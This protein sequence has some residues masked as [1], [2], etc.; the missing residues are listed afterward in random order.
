MKLLIKKAIASRNTAMAK[1]T[2]RNAEKWFPSTFEIALMLTGIV[3]FT[4]LVFNN[5]NEKS[6]IVYG[7]E[8]LGYWRKG[9]WELLE[10][11]MQMILI[12]VLGYALAVS[13]QVSNFLDIISKKADSNVKATLITALVS[14]F[15]G[16]L[17][18]GFGLIVGAIVARKI[19]DIAAKNSIGINYPL[20]AASGYLGM[21]VWHGGF[22]GSSTLKVAE[23]GHF[24]EDKVGVIPITETTLSTYNLMVYGVFLILLTFLVIR[25]S[26][27]SWRY[28]HLPDEPLKSTFIESGSG[29]NLGLYL[30]LIFIFLSVS[31]IW[32]EK[33][34]GLGVIDLNFINFLLLGI[35]LI[36]FRDVSAYFHAVSGG[37][38]SASDIMIQFPF[39]AGIMGMLKYSGY[40]RQLGLQIAESSSGDFFPLV[41]FLGAAFVNLFIP[42]GGGQWAIQGP[43]LMETA[44]NL[45]LSPSKVV[46]AFAYGDQLTNMLQ[47]FWALPLLA[48]T[49]LSA[50]SIFKYCF[51]YF[52][53]GLAVFGIA[54]LPIWGIF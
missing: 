46:L 4:I 6:P 26:R 48:I 27:K 35:G 9:F 11:T 40:L 13:P 10:F 25:L 14:V 8:I 29:K 42:S 19:G 41:A 44:V 12:L 20:V 16:Y 24:L 30:G 52:L 53:L 15:A 51:Y 2:L 33:G 38:K 37:M 45:G 36:L 22:S 7:I 32:V 54:L 5:P 34:Q 47:P 28:S 21:L 18:W 50:K 23:S 43:V 49:G 1:K 39:Y 3:F 31:S 17:N